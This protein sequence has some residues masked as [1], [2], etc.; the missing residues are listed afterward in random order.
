MIRVTVELLPHGME[1]GR[2]V[3]AT[4][5]IANDGAHLMRPAYGSYDARLYVHQTRNGKPK[6]WRRARVASMHRRQ[7]GVWDLLQLVLQDALGNRN[8]GGGR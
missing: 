6:L 7:R 5:D 1:L 2:K 8:R 4:A 3:L